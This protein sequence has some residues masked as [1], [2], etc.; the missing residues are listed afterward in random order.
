MASVPARCKN[1]RPP[2]EPAVVAFVTL[3]RTAP[4]PLAA[5][6]ALP[7]APRVVTAAPTTLDGRLAIEAYL[8]RLNHASPV[9]E[10]RITTWSPEGRDQLSVGAVVDCT[11]AHPD[12]FLGECRFGFGLDLR[13]CNPA[14]APPSYAIGLPLAG[15]MSVTLPGREV[16][17]AAGEGVVID[18]A[19]VERT[20]VSAGAH[21]VEFHLPRS[22]LLRLATDW[23]PGLEGRLPVFS[24]RLSA[25]LSQRLLFMAAQAAAVLET[26][27]AGAPSRMM[28]QRW[29]EMIA[30]TLLHEQGIDNTLA[31]RPGALAARPTPASVRRA[32]DFIH[33]NAGSAIGLA[34][35]AEAACTS[36]SSLLR[37]FQAQVGHTP[38]AFLRRVRLERARAELHGDSPD[39]IQDIALRWGFQNASKFSR[40][41]Q[42]QFG[43]RPSEARRR[44]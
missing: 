8:D 24:P 3:P 10:R 15:T 30:L 12:V 20:Q 16:A 33:A 36:A 6:N 25:P 40:A 21:L 32:I 22:E 31:A 43:Q 27:G 17:V 13:T 39:A 38:A 23:A 7:A 11:G 34:D 44:G 1:R 42:Q 19:Q 35:I 28:F 37:H 26:S 9:A 14:A 5:P 29:T 2:R 41:Y 18:P 4:A